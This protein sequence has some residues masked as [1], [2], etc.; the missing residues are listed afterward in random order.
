[1]ISYKVVLKFWSALYSSMNK[2]QSNDHQNVTMHCSANLHITLE[3]QFFDN[4]K[5]VL[6]YKT[7]NF[8]FSQYLQSVFFVYPLLP[9]CFP[10]WYESAWTSLSDLWPGQLGRKIHCCAASLWGKYIYTHIMWDRCRRFMLLV[11]ELNTKL[12]ILL[13]NNTV[14]L[15]QAAKKHTVDKAAEDIRSGLI[16]IYTVTLY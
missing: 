14:A 4:L 1:M 13:L 16:C 5:N 15:E 7:L 12:L 3:K 10:A 11:S 2:K 9:Q 8:Y 6:H